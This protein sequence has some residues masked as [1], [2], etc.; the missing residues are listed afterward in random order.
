MSDPG[1]R[2]SRFWER[3][4]TTVFLLAVLAVLA[5]LITPQVGSHGASRLMQDLNSL[6]QIGI[7]VTNYATKSDG[8]LPQS[9]FGGVGHSWRVALCAELDRTDIYRAYRTDAAWDAPE[10]R[11][12][13]ALWIPVMTSAYRP[14]PRHDAQKRGYADFGFITGPETANPPEG[15]LSI[16]EIS[17]ADGL[18]QTL[19]VGECSGLQLIWTEPRDPDVSREKIGIALVTSSKPTSDALLSSYSQYGV[20]AL[21][22]D[23]SGRQLSKDIDPKVLAAICTVNGGETIKHTDFVW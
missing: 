3:F 12:F 2:L 6:H 22:G 5:S 17:A 16:D 4:I 9:R 11:E 10:N 14:K 18:G 23:G 8:M 15:P 19:L 7:A 21:F 1:E 13:T 20:C